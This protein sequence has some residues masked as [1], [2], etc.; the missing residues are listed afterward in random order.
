[1]WGLGLDLGRGGLRNWGFF[2]GLGF[3]VQGF[4]SR[5]WGSAGL[6]VGRGV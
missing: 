4:E 6:G 5:A 2:L 3:R 1:M